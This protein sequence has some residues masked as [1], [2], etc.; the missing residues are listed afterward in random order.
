MVKEKTM[1]D[2][3]YSETCPYCQKVLTYF[4]ENNI[5]FCPKEVTN[6]INYDEL[7][8]L[9]KAAQVPFL[10]DTERGVRM[11]ESDRI[12]DYVKNLRK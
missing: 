10:S 1:L 12:I 8:T 5:D 6:P 3:Y 11:Y 7:I 9:G 4:K 2:L